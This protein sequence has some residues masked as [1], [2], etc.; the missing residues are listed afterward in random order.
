MRS[1]FPSS[2]NHREP[3]M[4]NVRLKSVQYS[5][6]KGR[7]KEWTLNDLTLGPINLIVGMNASGKTRTLNI[8][9]NLAKQFVPEPR[10]RP[11][12]CGYDLIFDNQGQ[13][14]R[15]VL[16][17][18]GGKVSKEEVYVDGGQLLSRGPGG[19]GEIFAKEEGKK[20]RFKP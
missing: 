9:S 1:R 15:Y 20:I 10:Y 8:I 18:D 16:V 12:N 19:E 7:P 2:M 4:T 13:Q 14:L 17:V 6:R 5:E 3:R 11:G